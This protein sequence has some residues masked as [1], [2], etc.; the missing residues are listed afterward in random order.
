MEV[1][2]KFTLEFHQPDAGLRTPDQLQ[3]CEKYKPLTEAELCHPEE[4][5][6]E[7]K[8]F[9]VE[10][11][12]FVVESVS[13]GGGTSS[14]QV[15]CRGL[16]FLPCVLSCTAGFKALK[17][18]FTH[19]TTNVLLT[20]Q[21]SSQRVVFIIKDI[22]VLCKNDRGQLLKLVEQ[23][24]WCRCVLV[25]GESHGLNWPSI[26][27]P[28]LSMEAKLVH[29]WW[30]ISQEGID[31]DPVQVERIASQDDLRSGLTLL[32]NPDGGMRD[33]VGMDPYSRGLCAFECL[34][35][36]DMDS[37]VEFEDLMC[38][39]D[40]G[41]RCTKSYFC[42]AVQVVVD[43]FVCVRRKQSFVARNA[44][45]CNRQ[46]QLTKC[47]KSLHI[48]VADIGPYGFLYRQWLLSN[49]IPPP[50]F[51]VRECKAVYTTAKIGVSSALCK[52]LKHILRI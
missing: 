7:L 15:L 43:R 33:Y 12:Y 32:Q 16:G 3:L 40:V 23:K 10:H 19:Q 5:I 18:H 51:G 2:D 31:I 4:T 6:Q 34:D 46:G 37:L 44:Q 52:R 11:R 17:D 39:L 45:I 8:R 41:E 50:G 1:V 29:M 42:D 49:K 9:L 22:R 20:L 38:H 48:P 26:S 24:S 13:G 28:P 36:D 14:V 27:L 35:V 21:M 25:V 30:I 47:A